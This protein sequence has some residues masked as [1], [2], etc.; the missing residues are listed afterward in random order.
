[1]SQRTLVHLSWAVGGLTLLP[2]PAVVVASVMSLA[3]PGSRGPVEL[4]VLGATFAY[5]LAW[6]VLWLLSGLALRAGRTGRALALASPPVLVAGAGA[7]LLAVGSLQSAWILQSFG[8]EDVARARAEN[9]L[10]ATLLDFSYGRGSWS[11]VEREIQ[12]ADPAMLSK[13]VAT[14][15]TPLRLVLRA[16][17]LSSFFEPEKTRPHMLDAAR[18]L[19]ARGAT[20][21]PQEVQEDAV[22]VW[23]ADALR[24]QVPLPDPVAA[25]ENPLVW[26][27][28]TVAPNDHSSMAMEIFEADDRLLN[29]PT[30][31]YGTPL[32]AALLRGFTDRAG[33]VIYN[34][35]VLSAAER[36]VASLARQVDRLLESRPDLREKYGRPAQA[37][38]E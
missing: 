13:P 29:T 31:T 25:Q 16:S 34:G 15:G 23:M 3:A 20:L 5:P 12:A 19:L 10:V 32:R 18:L 9:P 27:L 28:M 36:D 11:K 7:A 35:G 21:A 26:R 30:R 8:S 38:P 17:Q 6:A 33:D 2:Y 37:R 22:E 24:R 4:L 1:M 14:Y